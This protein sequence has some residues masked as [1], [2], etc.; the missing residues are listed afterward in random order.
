[1]QTLFLLLAVYESHS[2]PFERFCKDFLG[3]CTK[4]GRNLRSADRFPVAVNDHGMVDLRDAADYL[5]QIRAAAR[6]RRE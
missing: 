5:D 1:M 3:V 4:T 6:R 2:I